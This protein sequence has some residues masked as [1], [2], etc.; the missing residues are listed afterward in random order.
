MSGM[1]T[2]NSQNVPNTPKVNVKPM[3]VPE[4]KA[5]LQQIQEVGMTS[6]SLSLQPSF[7]HLI[8][9]MYKVTIPSYVASSSSS[10]SKLSHASS[11]CS[12]TP[13]LYYPK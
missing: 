7:A 5:M 2:S 8:N 4:F 10:V 3:Y 1:L 13:E 9:I 11:P 12:S 6:P